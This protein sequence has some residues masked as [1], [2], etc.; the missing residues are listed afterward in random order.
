MQQQS[1]INDNSDCRQSKQMSMPSLSN[2]YLGGTRDPD[3]DLNR[4]WSPSEK[5]QDPETEGG[6][7]SRIKMFLP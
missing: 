4:L 6:A 5:V 7:Y 2:V 3:A 1:V